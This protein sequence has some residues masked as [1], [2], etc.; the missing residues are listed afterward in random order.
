MAILFMRIAVFCK[1][2]DNWGDAGVCWR[3][4]RYLAKQPVKVSEVT[5]YVDGLETFTALGIGTE[6][7]QL[8][9]VSLREWPDDTSNTPIASDIIVAAFGCNLPQ[10]TRQALSIEAAS[11]EGQ[12]TLW[13]NLEYL[14]AEAWIDS[15]H[16]KPS[17]K[18]DGAC[19]MFFM[20]GFSESSG[21]ILGLDPDMQSVNTIAFLQKIGL[22]AKPKNHRW[23][24]I[25]CYPQAPADVFSQLTQPWTLLIP[26]SLELTLPSALPDHV[27]I[28][29]V[30]HLSQAEYDSLLGLCDLNFVRGEDSWVR[31]QLVQ[32]PLI[33]QPYMQ[34]DNTHSTKLEAFITTVAQE[35]GLNPLW[36]DAMRQWSQQPTLA[37]ANPIADLM[38]LNP[39][40]FDALA[41]IFSRWTQALT[42]KPTLD[43]NLLA[44][45]RQW[46]Q[47]AIG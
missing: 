41:E 25:F 34:A 4:C 32:A 2:V 37:F 9:G 45:Q 29:R 39:T 5:L 20:P 14:S 27:T 11:A 22:T 44:A 40:E 43:Q 15:H 26:K 1:V 6:L 3:L 33:W 23:A 31:A 35:V 46:R 36:A 42:A 12:S 24:S 7:A 28:H 18:P 19:E 47:R 13:I 16:W 21:G 8:H 30:P 17:I 38:N 10:A